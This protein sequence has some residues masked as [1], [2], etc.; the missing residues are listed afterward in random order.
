MYWAPAAAHAPHHIMKE[1]AD[2][3]KY[4][5]KFDD[6][7]DKYRERVFQ[8]QKE[9]WLSP[10]AYPTFGGPPQTRNLINIQPEREWGRVAVCRYSSRR[11][12]M[13]FLSDPG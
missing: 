12:F 5:G 4:K 6:G 9:L 13:Q 11:T 7:W 10:A 1:W 8:R 2:K 3:Y